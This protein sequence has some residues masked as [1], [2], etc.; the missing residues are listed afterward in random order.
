LVK[1][2][3]QLRQVTYIIASTLK[4]TGAG[5]IHEYF[6]GDFLILPTDFVGK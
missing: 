3:N 4:L 6:A 1:I 2:T 5:T